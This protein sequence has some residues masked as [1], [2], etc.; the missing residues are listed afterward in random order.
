MRIVPAMLIA[1]M[2]AAVLLASSCSSKG[3]KP[4]TENLDYKKLPTML[5]RNVETFISDS[6]ITR[7]HITSDLWKVYDEADEPYWL[8]PTGLFLE[9]YDDNLHRAAT[10]E[11]DSAIYYSNKRVWEL[12]G[13]V[14]MVNVAGDRFLTNQLFW[15]QDRHKVYSDSFIHIE[16][17]DRT[18]EGY[19]FE[20][21]D[22]MTSYTVN[23]PSGIFPASQ[24]RGGGEAAADSATTPQAKQPTSAPQPQAPT[25]SHLAQPQVSQQ[26]LHQQAQSSKPVPLMMQKASAGRQAK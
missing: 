8:F 24:F 5:T 14:R 19:G 12:D 11:A 10:V 6:G 25:P 15:D 23:N 1:A 26:Q 9:K 2:T 17:I 18:I 20:S 13:N 22:Q 21:N 7:Y 4:E 16:R 3:T